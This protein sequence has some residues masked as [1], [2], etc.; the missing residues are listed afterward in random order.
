MLK[1]NAGGLDWLIDRNGGHRPSIQSDLNRQMPATAIEDGPI[2]AVYGVV[3][4]RVI[5]LC[6]WSWNGYTISISKQTLSQERQQMG[7]HSLFTRPK[8]H[9]QARDAIETFTKTSWRVW[10]RSNA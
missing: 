9:G 4:W 5:D 1:L 6:Q 10:T 3:R 2:P 8:H 7:F